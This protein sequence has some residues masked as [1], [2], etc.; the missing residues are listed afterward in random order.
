MNE[1]ER[2]TKIKLNFRQ[3]KSR[4]KNRFRSGIRLVEN[5]SRSN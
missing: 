4:L 3:Q 1:T 2:P 5:T